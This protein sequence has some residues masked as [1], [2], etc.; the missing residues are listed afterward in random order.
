LDGNSDGKAIASTPIV[1]G[2]DEDTAN[3][4]TLAS[5]DNGEEKAKMVSEL[6]NGDAASSYKIVTPRADTSASPLIIEDANL[7][8]KGVDEKN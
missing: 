2:Y 6:D 4:D 7:L 1:T 3:N 5:L 8:A